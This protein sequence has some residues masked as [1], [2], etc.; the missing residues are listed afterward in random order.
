MAG[1]KLGMGAV[2]GR[3]QGWQLKGLRN[4]RFSSK[5]RPGNP[6]SYISIYD[7]NMGVLAQGYGPQK[8][9]SAADTTLV[10]T[11]PN[12]QTQRPYLWFAGHKP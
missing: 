2:L 8:Q 9:G 5:G 3:A 7:D 11:P 10:G 1:L 4:L 6:V 12:K